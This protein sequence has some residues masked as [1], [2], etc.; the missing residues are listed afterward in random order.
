MRA[1]STTRSRLP[2]EPWLS[3]TAVRL[4]DGTYQA[5]SSRPPDAAMVTS[6]CGIPSEASWIS[7]RGACVVRSAV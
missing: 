5:D 7:H 4:R 6:S 1:S 2:P 3:S